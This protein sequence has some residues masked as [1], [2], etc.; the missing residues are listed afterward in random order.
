MTGARL[1]ERIRQ[2]LDPETCVVLVPF[3]AAWQ[4][5]GHWPAFLWAG[6]VA[7]SSVFAP[8]LL[9]VRRTD[10]PPFARLQGYAAPLLGMAVMLV[11]G[12]PR[13]AVA[14]AAAMALVLF[15]TFAVRGSLQVAAFAGTVVAA[16]VFDWR[17]AAVIAIPL[18]AVCWARM[19][20]GDHTLARV[21]MSAV[22]GP[23]VGLA[24]F[25]LAR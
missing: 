3:F 9:V 17:L 18:V 8:Y 7:I 2:G 14:V 23:A 5:V 11:A 25:L 22:A 6:L 13:E 12:A 1:A 15:T 4:Q 19:R 16:A 10:R 24:V 20:L 21:A